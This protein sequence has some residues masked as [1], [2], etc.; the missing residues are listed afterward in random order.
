MDCSDSAADF[1]VLAKVAGSGRSACDTVA[2]TEAE[3]TLTR[4]STSL[5]ALC[6]KHT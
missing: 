3:F 1:L 6:L 5:Y 4:G 2:G